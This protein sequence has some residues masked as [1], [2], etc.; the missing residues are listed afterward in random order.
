MSVISYRRLY[1]PDLE[2]ETQAKAKI[3]A[4]LNTTK[5]VLSQK[6]A[7]RGRTFRLIGVPAIKTET[8]QDDRVRSGVMESIE[9][10]ITYSD[11]RR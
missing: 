11:K 2:T 7:A 3:M 9:V 10:T 4:A 1:N 5:S 6:L 8:L